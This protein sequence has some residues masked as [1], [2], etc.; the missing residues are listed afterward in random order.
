VITVK[1][2]GIG[3]YL[4]SYAGNLDIINCAAIATAEE[5]AKDYIKNLDHDDCKLLEEPYVNCID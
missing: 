3:D 2:Q 5:Y 4:P 1:V